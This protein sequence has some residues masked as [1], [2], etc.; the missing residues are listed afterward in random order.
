MKKHILSKYLNNNTIN[1]VSEHDNKKTIVTESCEIS[2]PDEF[3]LMNQSKET[4]SIEISDP[5]EFILGPTKL[6]FAKENSDPD[7]FM[8]KTNKIDIEVD[9]DEILLI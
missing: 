2:D 9:F 8:Y 3:Y 7:E 5:D 4:R 1:K 6:T